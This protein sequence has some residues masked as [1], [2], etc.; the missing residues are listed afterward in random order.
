[1]VKL[2]RKNIFCL[3]EEPSSLPKRKQVRKQQKRSTRAFHHQ[4]SALPKRKKVVL[5][6]KKVKEMSTRDIMEHVLRS[7]GGFPPEEIVL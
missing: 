1:M 5:N 3:E 2:D 7:V 6:I 4:N